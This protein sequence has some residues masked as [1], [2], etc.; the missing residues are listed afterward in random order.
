MQSVPTD[1]ISRIAEAYGHSVEQVL[2][3]QSGY[4][5]TSYPLVLVGGQLA[6]LIVYKREPLIL[7]RIQLANALGAHLRRHQLPVRYPLDRRITAISTSRGD[8]YASLYNY[9]PGHT[10]PWEAY[11]RHHIKLMG[12]AL[13]HMHEALRTSQAPAP[14]VADEYGVIFRHMSTYFSDMHVQRAMRQKLGLRLD[15]AY[16]AHYQRVLSRSRQF[17]GQQLLHLDFVRSNVL[18]GSTLDD[19]KARLKR[20]GIAITGIIDFEK[21]ALGHPIFDLARTLAFLLVDC[22]YKSPRQIY[23]QFLYSGYTKRGPVAYRSDWDRLLD[24]LIGLFLLHDFYKFLRHNPY[25]SLADNEHYVRTKDLLLRR[26]LIE[27]LEVSH[28]P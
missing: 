12:E 1:T 27:S 20:H 3:P 8:R 9:L 22:K 4:R 17:P 28:M 2:P 26:H 11:T 13:S 25:E 23:R 24:E 16:I 6:N 5:N 19:P 14:H 18:F 15:P 21:A 10:I 7:P